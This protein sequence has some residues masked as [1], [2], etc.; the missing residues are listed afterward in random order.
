M[1]FLTLQCTW[2]RYKVGNVGHRGKHRFVWTVIVRPAVS[3][4]QTDW[5]ALRGDR[6]AVSDKRDS[7]TGLECVRPT[8][9]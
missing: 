7:R 1:C 5:I 9:G 3:H 8:S 6:V 2:G 4:S